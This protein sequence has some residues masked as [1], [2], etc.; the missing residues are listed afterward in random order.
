MSLCFNNSDVL[1]RNQITVKT[2][3]ISPLLQSPAQ[4]TSQVS[5][6]PSDVA[7]CAGLLDL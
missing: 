6:C 4:H 3:D 1:H 2:Y 7:L 5:L